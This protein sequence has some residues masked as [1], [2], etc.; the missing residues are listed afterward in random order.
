[1]RE[2][3]RDM[4]VRL[5]GSGLGDGLQQTRQSHQNGEATFL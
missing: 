1:M 4:D 5:L 2:K 3:G